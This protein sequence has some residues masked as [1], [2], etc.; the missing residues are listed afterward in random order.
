M[1]FGVYFDTIFPSE[2]SKNLNLLHKYNAIVA[3][4]LPGS[5]VKE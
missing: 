4:P 3:K 1:Q 5:P 2:N